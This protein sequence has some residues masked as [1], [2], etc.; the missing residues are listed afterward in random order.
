MSHRQRKAVFALTAA[1]V[2]ILWSTVVAFAQSGVWMVIS[3]PN[4]GSTKYNDLLAIAPVSANDIWSVG[5]HNT[6]SAGPLDCKTR[7]LAEH[8]NGS[9][10]SIVSTPNAATGFGDYDPLEGVATVST[11]DV[12]AVGYSGNCN[13]IAEKTLIE[14][15][16]GSSWSIVPSPNP[17]TSQELHGITAV[18]ANDIWAVGE[19]YSQSKNGGMYGPL[20]EHWNGTMWSK[21]A[22]PVN[23]GLLY[24]V[25][26]LADNNVWAVGEIITSGGSYILHWNGTKWSIVTSPQP[27]N[28][29]TYFLNSVTAVSASNIWAVGTDFYNNGEGIANKA[30]I[31]HWDGSSWTLVSG[32]GADFLNG[33][34]ALSATNVWAVGGDGYGL[35]FVEKWNGTQWV[36]MSSP[37]PGNGDAFDA[38][39][40]IPTSGDVWAVGEYYEATS[41]Y[42]SQ[43]LV[44]QCMAC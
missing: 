33:V 42:T 26:A 2:A 24:G 5:Y 38:V 8:W 40:A 27:P 16:N 29:N 10:W 12:W 36:R 39:A 13:S 11:S 22:A 32:V 20:I 41:P 35:S 17:Y 43:T 19:Y 30:M 7:T 31:E 21:V 18:S 4:T 23:G 34:T 28:G 14:H 9:K 44:E 15:W 1:L 37:N 6:D 3:S 25:T